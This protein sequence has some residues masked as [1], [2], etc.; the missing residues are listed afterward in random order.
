MSKQDGAL[1]EYLGSKL[2]ATVAGK[3][4]YNLYVLSTTQ[5]ETDSPTPNLNPTAKRRR[6]IVFLAEDAIFVTALE[7]HEYIED[8]GENDTVSLYISKVDTTGF[9]SESGSPT[10]PLITSFLKYY[11]E[12]CSP[13]QMCSLEL[14]SS[15][16]LPNP[17]K[18]L[19]SAF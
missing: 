6:F 7:V 4:T 14:N 13:K 16:F 1:V 3:H 19:I 18:T 2:S 5:V 9:S 17:L 12:I 8:H 11:I 10:K 15:T